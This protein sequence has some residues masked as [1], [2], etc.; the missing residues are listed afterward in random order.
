MAVDATQLTCYITCEGCRQKA[1]VPRAARFCPLC[2][3]A[4]EPE[5]TIA[6]LLAELGEAKKSIR[7][8]QEKAGETP[9][10]EEEASK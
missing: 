2:G 6:R 9:D 8:W 4:Y 5:K 7:Y 10:P 3:A 1:A